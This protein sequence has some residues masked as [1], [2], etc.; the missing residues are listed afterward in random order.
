M[1]SQGLE[2]TEMASDILSID[3]GGSSVKVGLFSSKVFEFSRGLSQRLPE[4]RI[5]GRTFAQVKDAVFEAINSALTNGLSFQSIA[6]STSGSVS[7]DGVVISSGHFIDYERIDWRRL[8]L[9]EFQ[10]VARV[11]V[12]NDGKASAWAEYRYLGFDH[13]SG[14]GVIAS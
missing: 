12:F 7:E 5:L 6:I 9:P 4:V 1:S 14:R 11:N 8:I 10:A 3:I 13:N 2:G